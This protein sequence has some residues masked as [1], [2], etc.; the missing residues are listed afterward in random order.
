MSTGFDA[1]RNIVIAPDSTQE[2]ARN[3]PNRPA[4][5]RR[6][7]PS[8]L[9]STTTLTTLAVTQRRRGPLAGARSVRTQR[10]NKGTRLPNIIMERAEMKL[11]THTTQHTAPQ[12][13]YT[14]PVHDFD[15]ATIAAPPLFVPAPFRATRKIVSNCLASS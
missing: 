14:Y 5:Y 15:A 12:L 6:M 1:T 3:S 9:V 8:G 7:Q 11:P 13:W 10:A 4:E 2:D